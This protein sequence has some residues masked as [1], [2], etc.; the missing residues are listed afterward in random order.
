MKLKMAPN[1]L[2]A[3][4]LRSRW[5]ISFAVTAVIVLLALALLPTEFKLVGALG[6]TPF[7]AIGCVALVRQWNAP[8]PARIQALLGQASAQNWAQFSAW[9]E[10]AWRAEGYTVQRPAQGPIDFRLERA[11][12]V[13]LVQ[14]KR[15]KA[16]H[17][18]VE[19]LRELL[20]ARSAAGAQDVVYVALNP[21]HDNARLLARDEAVVVLQDADLAGL[22]EKAPDPR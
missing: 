3:I 8:S 9:L 6:A 2:F 5:W 15:W 10:A 7:F 12:R 16:A 19:P 1:S 13:A 20:A 11:G 17:H 21:L 18:G 4:L 14:A 22:L